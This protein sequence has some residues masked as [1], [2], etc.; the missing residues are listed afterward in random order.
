MLDSTSTELE[1]QGDVVTWLNKEI[2][3][4]PGMHLDKASQEVSRVTRKRNDVVVWFNRK[5]GAAFLT[6][7]LNTPATSLTDPDLLTDAEKK[8]KRWRAPFFAI[9]NMQGAELYRTPPEGQE[10]TPADCLKRW[11]PDPLVRTVKDLLQESANRSLQKRA[12]EI[13]DEAWTRHTGASG[14]LT[15]DASVFVDRIGQ[16]I[17][18][19]RDLVRSALRGRLAQHPE[20]RRKLRALASAQGMLG[21]V[22]DL[23]GAVAGQYAYRVV[24]QVL[25]YFALRRRQG[26]L[27]ALE[28]STASPLPAALRP[29]WDDVRRFDYE[30]LYQPHELDE[31]VP[32]PTQAD[33]LVRQLIGEFSAYDW[34]SLRDDVLGSIF[35]HLITRE[36]QALLGEF[37]TPPPRSGPDRRPNCQCGVGGYSRPRLRKRH[38]SHASVRLPPS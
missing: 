14:G 2:A 23:E 27:R 5:A 30:A 32:F 20:L 22:Q 19:L 34:N 1:F 35:E 38:L 10:T 8:A 26:A 21:F 12:C 6:I 17:A 33:E 29:Y 4:R 24:G 37:Y 36:E 3:R 31:I 15:I 13:L 11:V 28:P 16:R 7:E 9:W 18:Q 25:F